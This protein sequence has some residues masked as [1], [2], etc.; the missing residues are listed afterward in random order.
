[1]ERGR[2]DKQELDGLPQRKVSFVSPLWAAVLLVALSPVVAG[3]FPIFGY[4]HNAW[5]QVGMAGVAAWALWPSRQAPPTLFLTP[6]SIGL[7]AIAG[8][9]YFST[10]WATNTFL[11]AMAALHWQTV[12]ICF[13]VVHSQLKEEREARILL[14]VLALS[15]LFVA[16]LGV[17]QALFAVDWV[18]QISRPASTFGNANMAAHFLVLLW[19][20]AL[21]LVLASTSWRGRGFFGFVL[22]VSL[23]YLLQTQTRAA[24][25]ASLVMVLAWLW[26]AVYFRKTREGK[27]L[28]RRLLGAGF[29]LVL[30]FSLAALSIEGFGE[31]LYDSIGKRIELIELSDGIAGMAKGRAPMFVNTASMVAAS[32]PFGVGG[33]NWPVHYPA[34]QNAVLLDKPH[35]ETNASARSPHNDILQLTAEYGVFGMLGLGLVGASLLSALRGLRSRPFS[36][37]ILQISAAIG[38]LGLLVNMQ[39]SFPLQ[40]TIASCTAACLL[41][42]ALWPEPQGWAF[43]V[44]RKLA[45]FGSVLLMVLT[46]ALASVLAL[47]L[48]AYHFAGYEA[49]GHNRIAD[50]LLRDSDNRARVEYYDEKIKEHPDRPIFSKHRSRFLKRLEGLEGHTADSERRLALEHIDAAIGLEPYNP[51]HRLR[52]VLILDRLEE[53]TDLSAEAEDL[54]VVYPHRRSVLLGAVKA[55]LKLEQPERALPHATRLATNAP[56][57]FSGNET[58]GTVFS[59]LGRADSACF[60]FRRAIA[61]D[62]AH[63]SAE[64][65]AA[66][67]EEWMPEA[68]QGGD[69]GD[70]GDGGEGSEKGA[71]GRGE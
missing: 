59:H 42:V 53:W 31:R 14:G 54:L 26:A 57:G 8:A 61:N 9:A 10:L 3:A 50:S 46:S 2:S 70:G 71:G 52:K 67:C 35:G 44:P 41:A 40:R 45:G 17:I 63:R 68:A 51:A 4:V 6:A 15:L 21:G 56:L 20:V 38:L 30:A 23:G 11:A 25:L 36:V 5:L 37:A 64:A 16:G 60:Y 69:G 32:M 22:L 18:P 62:P 47:A 33:G 12:L 58:L 27:V 24:L 34:Y 39:F 49:W 28:A 13:L 19:P 65:L 29:A 55:Y 66:Y 43:S 48:A 7:F 1:M